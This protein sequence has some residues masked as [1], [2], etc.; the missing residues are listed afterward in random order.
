MAEFTSARVEVEVVIAP[1][2][3]EI[4]DSLRALSEIIQKSGLSVEEFTQLIQRLK[5]A[6]NDP[7]RNFL[8]GANRTSFKGLHKGPSNLEATPG[9]ERETFTKDWDPRPCEIFPQWRD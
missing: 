6:I 1:E 2:D 9:Q 4:I 8:N 7:E 5:D 3:R